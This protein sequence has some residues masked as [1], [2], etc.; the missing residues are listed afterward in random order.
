M[1]AWFL[2]IYIFSQTDNTVAVQRY[3]VDAQ[4]C[5]LFERQYKLQHM[6]DILEKKMEVFCSHERI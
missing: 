3:Q 5:R 1:T 6:Q 2:Y 4:D